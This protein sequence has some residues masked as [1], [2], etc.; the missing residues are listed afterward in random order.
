MDILDLDRRALAASTRIVGMITPDQL[1]EPTPCAQWVI[2]DLLRHMAGQNE[3]FAATA[4][5]ERP[6]ASVW[7]G[8]PHD[9]QPAARFA[10]SADLVNRAFAV[11]GVLDMRF[12]L[13]GVGS[14][15]AATAIGFHFVDYLIHAWDVA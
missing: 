10:E 6:A 1:G 5:G 9:G 4:R 8:S 2:R 14:F 7:E 3:G 12:E 13:P 15:P 11:P